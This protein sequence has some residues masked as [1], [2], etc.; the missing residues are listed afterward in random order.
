MEIQGRCDRWVGALVAV[1]RHDTLRH[2]G[3]EPIWLAPLV[4][5]VVDV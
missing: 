5:H 2:E 4:S 3:G 1:A